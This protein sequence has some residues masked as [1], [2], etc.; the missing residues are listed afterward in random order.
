MALPVQGG[1]TSKIFILGKT[2]NISYSFRT[3]SAFPE[4][5]FLFIQCFIL[6][7]F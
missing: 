5:L 4:F 6:I 2:K 1:S 3:L 7:I